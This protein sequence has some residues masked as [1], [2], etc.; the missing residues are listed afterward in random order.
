[1]A[2]CLA[3][4]RCSVNGS[5]DNTLSYSS[6]FP[7]HE[8]SM[9]SHCP[10]KNAM[11]LSLCS[12]CPAPLQPRLSHTPHSSHRDKLA[13]N[14]LTR[15]L[16]NPWSFAHIVPASWNTLPCLLPGEQTP[17]LS[18]GPSMYVAFSGKSSLTLAGWA[19]ASI[20]RASTS[21]LTAPS[22]QGASHPYP[23]S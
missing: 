7:V 1:M 14:P 2:Q 17:F 5:G 19:K 13:I 15:V 21:D 6:L 9:A 23:N 10:Q 12:L 20:S 11:F 8:P 3:H 16:F 4:S 18:L 22:M